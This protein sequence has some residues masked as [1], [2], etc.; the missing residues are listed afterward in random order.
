M[1]IHNIYTPNQV[2]KVL[3]N[4]SKITIPFWTLW[5]VKNQNQSSI[6]PDLSQFEGSYLFCHKLCEQ[7][8]NAKL[9]VLFAPILLLLIT[10]PDID[11][12]HH[13][14]T[15]CLLLHCI[16]PGYSYCLL[17]SSARGRSIYWQAFGRASINIFENYWHDEWI[18]LINPIISYL[19]WLENMYN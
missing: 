12:L 10:I 3:G 13:I 9:P 15:V 14:K 2:L 7:Y 11:K 1:N 6:F 16:V 17:L 19:N 5:I 4:L 8:G 18:G